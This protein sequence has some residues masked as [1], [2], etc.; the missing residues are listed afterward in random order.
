MTGITLLFDHARAEQYA[1]IILHWLPR[2]FFFQPIHSIGSSYVTEIR[3]TS[4]LI[5]R[6][7]RAYFVQKIEESFVMGRLL[8]IL[9]LCA[10]ATFGQQKMGT[11][12]GQVADEFGGVIVGSTVVAVDANGIEK[13]ATTNGDGAYVINGFAPGRY[14]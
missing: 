9:I 13:T 10:G 7:S 12:K 4:S 1:K 5:A 3:L 8:L 6:L 14:T 11:L 2:Q